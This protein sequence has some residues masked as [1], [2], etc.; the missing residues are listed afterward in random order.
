MTSASDYGKIELI[1]AHELESKIR[2]IWNAD[3]EAAYF[4]QHP[5]ARAKRSVGLK[6]VVPHCDRGLTVFEAQR[7]GHL[8]FHA[9]TS[10][11]VIGNTYVKNRYFEFERLIS[12]KRERYD[13]LFTDK[14]TSSLPSENALRLFC[15]EAAKRLRDI[16]KPSFDTW[17]EEYARFCTKS[18]GER[19]GAIGWR[20]C[21]DWRAQL[22]AA[23]DW[24]QDEAHVQVANDLMISCVCSIVGHYHVAFGGEELTSADWMLVASTILPDSTLSQLDEQIDLFRQTTGAMHDLE[25][26]LITTKR[27][28]RLSLT[29]VASSALPV[30]ISELIEQTLDRAYWHGRWLE[31]EMNA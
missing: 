21:S 15:E 29:N 22:G 5:I 12:T 8:L 6:V 25:N 14:R 30:E 28:F 7:G 3:S 16:D 20:L 27:S 10:G 23:S 9:R 4:R 19:I 18:R 11:E 24:L 1:R 26:A 2:E 31:P 17:A 13:L